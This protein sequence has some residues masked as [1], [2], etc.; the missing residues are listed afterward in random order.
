VVKALADGFRVHGPSAIGQAA[1]LSV[2][3]AATREHNDHIY[4][5]LSALWEK[6]G[7]GNLVFDI[8]AEC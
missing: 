7:K 5:Q 4:P 8:V 2:M 1:Y 3:P 6:L